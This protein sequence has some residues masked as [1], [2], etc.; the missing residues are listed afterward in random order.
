[1]DQNLKKLKRFDA[2][3][4]LESLP[5]AKDL[6]KYWDKKFALKNPEKFDLV[7]TLGGDGTVLY[8]QTCFKG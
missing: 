7:L 4:I 1:M 2:S 8:A 3:D 6:L 5:R